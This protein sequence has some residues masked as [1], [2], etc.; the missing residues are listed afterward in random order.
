MSPRTIRLWIAVLG[1]AF[2]ITANDSPLDRR[3]LRGLTAF[4]V[5]VDAPEPE[6]Q[7]RGLSVV[8]VQTEVEQRLLKTGLHLDR[9]ANEFLGIRII[10]AH[11]KKT[12]FAICIVLAAYQAVSLKRDPTIVS[13]TPTWSAE[14][15]LLVPPRQFREA[16][17]ETIHQLVDEFVNAW[18]A[19]NVVRGK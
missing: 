6:L 5:A 18:E 13:A 9:N 4:N 7:D 3:T 14:S 10:A 16:W 1:T 19:A 2:Q 15:V 11:G 17:I 8:A 12:D